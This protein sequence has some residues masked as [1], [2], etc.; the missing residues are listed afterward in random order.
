MIIHI[1][2]NI[3]FYLSEIIVKSVKLSINFKKLYT[4]IQSNNIQLNN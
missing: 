1:I 3:W 4:V 2:L